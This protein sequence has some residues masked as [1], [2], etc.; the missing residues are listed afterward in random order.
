MAEPV[1]KPAK[2]ASEPQIEFAMDDFTVVLPFVPA[3]PPPPSPPPPPPPPPRPPPPPGAAA[4]AAEGEGAYAAIPYV[5]NYYAYCEDKARL[6]T[7]EC[8][9]HWRAVPRLSLRGRARPRV[10]GPPARRGPAGVCEL[11][12]LFAKKRRGQSSR[13]AGGQP[14]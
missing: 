6:E 7:P 8:L 2:S 12:A 11:R 10:R 13:G 14:S 3:A 1:E 5:N 9:R 4:A